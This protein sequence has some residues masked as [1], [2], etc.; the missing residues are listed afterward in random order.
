MG[1]RAATLAL[2]LFI[3]VG[4][5]VFPLLYPGWPTL[6]FAF[7]GALGAILIG[8]L[9]LLLRAYETFASAQKQ[10]LDAMTQAKLAPPEPVVALL[11][12][13]S[14]PP[15]E[16]PLQQADLEKSLQGGLVPLREELIL[17]REQTHGPLM[18]VRGQLTQLREQTHGPLV[19]VRGQLT[20]LREQTQAPLIELRGQLGE[21]RA[22]LN[23]LRQEVTQMRD[24]MRGAIGEIVAFVRKPPPPAAPPP[25]A[26]VPTATEGAVRLV[27]TSLTRL[28]ESLEQRLSTLSDK[29]DHAHAALAESSAL[30]RLLSTQ[31]EGCG[32]E[33]PQHDL[34]LRQAVQQ[35]Q[36]ALEQAVQQTLQQTQ[37]ALEQAVQKTQSALDALGE[38]VQ[39]AS[40]A[41]AQAIGDG[42]T[43]TVRIFTGV[44]KQLD[45]TAAHVQE[46]LAGAR[47]TGEEL[48][49]IRVGLEGVIA[50]VAA[51]K[52]E[53]PEDN[54]QIQAL[55]ENLEAAHKEVMDQGKTL[56]K[57][58][59][60]AR[61]EQNTLAGTL[62]R[63]RKGVE[64]LDNP[65]R[66][67]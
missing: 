36:S 39:A 24:Q 37:S 4:I 54:E 49:K 14:L 30:L 3:L 66:R 10:A 46:V 64:K 7:S 8:G 52:V 38:K 9:G 25:V 43:Q 13:P 33:A 32:K 59:S 6:T 56:E 23:E 53:Q 18:E 17:I 65:A 55:S 11:P 45:G 50:R 26:L 40:R 12:P 63:V 61:A 57:L 27:S 20:Q 51:L 42:C 41:G 58:L 35:T 44:G 29:A 62:D 67:F 1:Q 5:G 2:P 31:K 34:A 28:S 15:V 60:L 21:L 47:A 48:R 16:P 22:Q 19:E